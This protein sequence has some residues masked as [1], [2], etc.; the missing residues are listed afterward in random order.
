MNAIRAD[1]IF[2]CLDERD[3]LPWVLGRVPSGWRAIVVDN[4]SS[5]GSGQ[6]AAELG[7]T[8]VVEPRRGFGAA[9]HAG[10]E[11][12]SA[13]FAAV[14]DADGSLDPA[15]L[16]RLLS[17]L[18]DGD[19]DLVLG[20]RR[21]DRG[22]WP[23]HARL[24]NAALSAVLRSAALRVGSRVPLTDLGP[25]RMAR[26]DALRGL[27]LRD[28]RSGYPLEM[29]LRAAE[30]GWRITEL[31]V[32]Y[33]PRVGRSKVTGTVRGTLTAVRDMAALLAEHRPPLGRPADDGAR[34][35]AAPELTI[36]VVAKE[37]V[38]GRVKTRLC[39]PFS[40][41]EAAL[42][43]TSSLEATLGV[44]RSLPARRRVLFFEGDPSAADPA[45]FEVLAQPSGDLDARLAALFDTVDGPLLVLGMDTPQLT[46]DD[47]APLFD[48]WRR[49][50]GADAWFGPAV[51]GGFWALALARPDG[52]L[53]RGVPMSRPDTGRRQLDRLRR[54]RLTVGELPPLRD[55]D[56]AADARDV[57]AT[58]PGTDFAA[59]VARVLGAVAHGALGSAEAAP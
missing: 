57:A 47:L 37:C 40:P 35:P 10:L 48:D 58:L 14:C 51:D 43:A 15:D 52:R 16:P 3:A 19:A 7:A 26:T 22:A 12:A 53:I 21:P 49:A 36:A 50:D 29:V 18:E 59:A 23:L 5:D 11:R 41:E 6:L 54:A 42:V 55:V 46:R 9:V 20:A 27:G 34:R 28:R 25:L 44:V 2:P 17:A 1:V 45:G 33:A 32:R 8:V 31:P 4:G 24:A 39:P 38:P 13:P 30:A 56:T